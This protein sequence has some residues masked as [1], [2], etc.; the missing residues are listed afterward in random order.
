MNPT[1]LARAFQE[2]RFV[3][4]EGPIVPRRAMLTRKSLLLFS[5]DLV[6]KLRRPR[7]IDG[8]D[9]SLMSVRYAMV[10]RERWIGRQLNGEVYLDDCVLRPDANFD[11][12]ILHRGFIEGEPLV[13]MRRL[14]DAQRADRLL[15]AGLAPEEARRPLE[16]AMLRLAR[17]HANAEHFTDPLHG[18]AARIH[19]R[20]TGVLETLMPVLV[21]AEHERLLDETGEWIATLEPTFAHRVAERRV[22]TLHGEVRLEHLFLPGGGLADATFIDPN[23]GPDEERTLD[24]GEEV[25]SLAL[26]LDMLLG[27]ELSDRVVDTYASETADATLRKVSRFYKRLGCLRRASEA[28]LDA[29]EPEPDVAEAEGRA[30]FFIERALTI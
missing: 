20:F 18:D 28:L 24:T 26:E 16:Q 22:R 25:M 7:L 6:L 12:V 3:G 27:R 15:L 9:Q 17:F 4:P 14:P 5:D 11:K 10:G 21:P 19:G 23:D 30:R 13:M 2:E 29:A 1:E 8:Y